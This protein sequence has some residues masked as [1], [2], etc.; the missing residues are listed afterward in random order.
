MELQSTVTDSTVHATLRGS[1]VFSDNGAFK[2]L[3]DHA[4]NSVVSQI[5]LDL[6][7]LEFIDSA[8][9]GMLLLLRDA[10]DKHKKR[11][12]LRHP[13]GQVKKVFDLSRFEHLFTIEE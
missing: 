9:L 2:P 11:L 12:T 6:S 10:C 7:A 4:A 3:L 5:T 8:G 13:F 1:F